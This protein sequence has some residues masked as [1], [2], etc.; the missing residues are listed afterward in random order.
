ME[1]SAE[2]GNG[3]FGSG[4]TDAVEPVSLSLRDR[5]IARRLHNNDVMDVAPKRFDSGSEPMLAEGKFLRVNAFKKPVQVSVEP[6][7]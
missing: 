2:T 1:A 6:L 4:A 5:N 3:E 7:S